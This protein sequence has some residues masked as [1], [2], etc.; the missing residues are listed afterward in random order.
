MPTI[1]MRKNKKIRRWRRRRIRMKNELLLIL[2]KIM[3]RTKAT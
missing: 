2:R 1:L 3:K